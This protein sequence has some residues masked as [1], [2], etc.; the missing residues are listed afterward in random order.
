MAYA[1]RSRTA[2]SRSLATNL[3]VS[4][5]APRR[6]ALGSDREPRRAGRCPVS[7]P[8]RGDG[9]RRESLPRPSP[10]RSLRACPP[11]RRRFPVSAALS[12]RREPPDVPRRPGSRV[13]GSRRRCCPP[14]SGRGRF[15]REGPP[16]LGGD[17]ERRVESRSPPGESVRRPGSARRL[18]RGVSGAFTRPPRRVPGARRAPNPM[19]PSCAYLAAVPGR[20]GPP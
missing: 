5:A 8:R 19:P 20:A 1:S 2:R 6:A 3:G 13:S 16:V 15:P 18:P 4:T 12:P 7:A 9:A 11:A 17:A 10:A 14:L